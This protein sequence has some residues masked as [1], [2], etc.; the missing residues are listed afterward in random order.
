MKII[1][2]ILLGIS[3]LNVY[4]NESLEFKN[5]E[6]NLKKQIT[7]NKKQQKDIDY[8]TTLVKKQDRSIK[9]I[10]ELLKI[11][12]DKLSNISRDI[13]NIRY[14][15]EKSFVGL[16]D[17][18]QKMKESTSLFIEDSNLE[19]VR[20]SNKMLSIEDNL[21]D[22][23]NKFSELNSNVSIYL[24]YILSGGLGVATILLIFYLLLHRR[25]NFDKQY[26]IDMINRTRNKL[27]EETVKLDNKLIE[28]LENKIQLANFNA[29]HSSLEDEQD[30]SLALKVADEI[31]RIQKNIAN[32]DSATKG[33][34]Q[35][36][37]SVKRIQDNFLA[38]G[39]ELVDMLGRE[40]QEGM[41]AI[42]NFVTSD[43][44][45]TGKQIISR[46]I[47]PQVNF[48][49]VMIQAAQIEV[50]IGE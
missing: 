29:I 11:N 42:A 16:Q 8:L 10:K 31:I 17:D 36:S 49:G 21:V 41:N 22:A 38:N 1:W 45:D 48:N 32:M 14:S 47:K 46:I 30:H 19:K 43:Q 5:L 27:E 9:E 6:N 3:S 44:I 40:Y 26:S 34:K 23:N 4:A 12:N 24:K 18:L 37:A 20:V 35:L 50:M 2:G 25:V 28:L 13:D 7:I 39:Y 15:G 33:L